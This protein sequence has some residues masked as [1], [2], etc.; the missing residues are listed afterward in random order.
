MLFFDFTHKH[1]SCTLAGKF[2]LSQARRFARLDRL[3]GSE[4]K[5]LKR[6]KRRIVDEAQEMPNVPPE[7]RLTSFPVDS[8][9]ST[10]LVKQLFDDDELADQAI[11]LAMCLA[12]VTNNANR[13]NHHFLHAF[14]YV[15]ILQFG[16]SAK[17]LSKTEID[18][19]FERKHWIPL[20][21]ARYYDTLLDRL[22]FGRISDAND[23]FHEYSWLRA[24]GVF[25]PWFIRIT[26]VL[27]HWFSVY[28]KL[29]YNA[30]ESLITAH[31][32][33][34][35]PTRREMEK[36]VQ[37]VE[38]SVQNFVAEYVRRLFKHS[39]PPRVDWSW[40]QFAPDG[41]LI[42][43]Q[44]TGVHCGHIVARLATT[45]ALQPST[46]GLSLA[47]YSEDRDEL[48]KMSTLIV[49]RILC[50]CA[51]LNDLLSCCWPDS[52]VSDT[53]AYVLSNG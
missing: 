51:R 50:V 42:P 2:V 41:E 1:L 23:D 14:D 44:A 31:G 32:F 4:S 37:E 52:F 9:V 18:L 11:D 36:T 34:W 43:E 45:I 16:N 3:S 24:E 22:K 30:S 12:Q 29:D 35:D 53:K 47:V 15:T 46:N 39:V 7:L 48:I 20:P 25:V 21:G 40:S 28:F 17:P 33:V 13:N 38:T 8:F 6:L 19:I 27:H 26:A 10:R 5:A 49:K